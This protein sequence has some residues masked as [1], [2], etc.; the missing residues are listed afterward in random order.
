MWRKSEHLAH[1]GSHHLPLGQQGV[2]LYLVDHRLHLGYLQ[3]LLHLSQNLTKIE[4]SD[5]KQQ[6]KM[7]GKLSPSTSGLLKWQSTVYEIR[8]HNAFPLE[9]R[10]FPCLLRCGN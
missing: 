7:Q 9:W 8:G 3:Q 5:T 6:N 4:P 10:E 2:Q 1:A